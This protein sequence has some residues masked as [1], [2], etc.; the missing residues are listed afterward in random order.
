MPLV[1]ELSVYLQFMHQAA[2]MNNTQY[3]ERPNIYIS[4]L[5]LILIMM[6]RALIR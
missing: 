2:K 6:K 5:G 3:L 4:K 1:N